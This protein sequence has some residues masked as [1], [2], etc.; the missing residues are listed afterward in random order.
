MREFI[1]TLCQHLS[2][3]LR[4]DGQIHKDASFENW[5]R[6][7]L[8]I[9]KTCTKWRNW[10]SNVRSSHK[11][12][13]P[14]RPHQWRLASIERRNCIKSFTTCRRWNHLSAPSVRPALPWYQNQMKTGQEHYSSKPSGAQI[15]K[16]FAR[17]YTHTKYTRVWEDHRPPW[18]DGIYPRNAKLAWQELKMISSWSM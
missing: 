7:T 9:G 14:R 15:Q 6:K 5:F 4:W 12:I 2:R 18:G 11:A 8:K 3:Q 16:S 13:L 17:Y 10:I 1:I